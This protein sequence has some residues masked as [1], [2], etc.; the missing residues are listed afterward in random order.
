MATPFFREQGSGTT[1]VCLHSNASSSSQWRLLCELLSSRFHVIAVDGYGSGKSPP[2]PSGFALR[3]EDEAR[4]VGAVLPPA[5]EQFHLVG[6]SYGAAVAMKLALMQPERVRSIVIYEP[7]LFHLVIGSEP[8][9]SPAEGIWRAASDAADAVD[10]GNERTGAE[11]FIDFWMGPGSWAAMPESR[12]AAVAVATRNVRGWRDALG[13]ETAPLAAFG[14]RTRR[15][16]RCPSC[17]CWQAR[18]QTPLWRRN[19][20]SG[21]WGR[22]L[23]QRSSTRRS[24]SSCSAT[25]ARDLRRA[26]S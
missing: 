17:V 8:L 5:P 4:L 26:S 2:W 10:A 21:T 11:R 25:E 23:I 15:S 18:C 12:Q 13:A 14:A 22:S 7:T 1:V 24:L 6:H 20:G 9:R 3:L 19:P 16:R